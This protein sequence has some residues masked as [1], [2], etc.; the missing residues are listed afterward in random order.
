M[1]V[2]VFVPAFSEKAFIGKR[3]APIRSQRS[4]IYLRTRSSALSIVPPPMPLVVIKAIT[5]PERT[6]SMDLAKK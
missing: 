5:P 6:L 3:T 1:S 4:A 2:L